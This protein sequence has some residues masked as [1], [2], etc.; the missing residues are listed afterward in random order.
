MSSF[1]Q[2]QEFPPKGLGI[3]PKPFY[4]STENKFASTG[5]LQKVT[6]IHT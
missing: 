6:F 2:K 5:L 1:G 4:P 3:G